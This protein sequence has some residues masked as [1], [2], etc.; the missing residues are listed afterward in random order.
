MSLAVLRKSY[1]PATHLFFSHGF[2]FTAARIC[3]QILRARKFIV[4]M[5]AGK[6]RA[7]HCATKKCKRLLGSQQNR[8]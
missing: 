1:P 3:C 4:E 2:A 5:S 6:S 7:Q 8:I